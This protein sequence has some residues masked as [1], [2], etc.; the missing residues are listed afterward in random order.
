MQTTN[1][2]DL[3]GL[4]QYS[5]ENGKRFAWPSITGNLEAEWKRVLDEYVVGKTVLDA[6]CGGGGFVRYLSQKGLDAVGVDRHE[7]FLEF[8]RAHHPE[9]RF[10]QADLTRPLPF[11]DGEFATTCCF[12]VLEHI[13]DHTAIREL[14]RVTRRRL[15]IAVP[16]DAQELVR[17]RV[18]YSHY[19]DKTHLR[20]YTEETLR[21][22]AESVSPQR[23]TIFGARPMLLAEMCRDHC[24]PASKYRL[25]TPLYRRAFRF[26]VGRIAQPGF[27]SSLVAVVDLRGDE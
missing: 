20:N 23:V 8:A 15:I 6:G 19:R 9:A 17:Y 25:L 13:D 1:H 27:Y 11:G 22:L 10:V 26:L 7:E 18:V 16:N 5:L 14:A 21:E 3:S 12:D 24:S 2:T 4:D